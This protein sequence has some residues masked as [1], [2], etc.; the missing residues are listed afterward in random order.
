[1]AAPEEEAEEPRPRRAKE[2]LLTYDDLKP[3]MQKCFKILNE[4]TTHKQAW[5]FREPVDA[6]ALGVPEYYTII[7]NPM[8]LGTIHNKLLS[9]KYKVIEVGF[10]KI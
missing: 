7:K 9:G 8:D 3:E 6:V 10:F 5:P 2:Q 4:I 1:M